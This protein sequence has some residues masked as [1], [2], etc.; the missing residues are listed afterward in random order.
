MV[1]F[2]IIS[3]KFYSSIHLFVEDKE[4]LLKNSGFDYLQA[5]Q[6]QTFVLPCMPTHPEVNVTLWRNDKPVKD[7]YISYDPKVSHYLIM[8][9]NDSQQ[10]A[11]CDTNCLVRE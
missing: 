11:N 3:F 5:I 8:N 10:K 9:E 6:T 7:N 4:H 2:R 1:T